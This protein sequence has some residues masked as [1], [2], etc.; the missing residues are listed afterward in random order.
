[1]VWQIHPAGCSLATVDLGH[2]GAQLGIHW[3]RVKIN[4][5]SK[6]FL[7]KNRRGFA[8]GDLKEGPLH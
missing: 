8:G 3:T 6:G 2:Y 5:T 1:M 7:L 4:E